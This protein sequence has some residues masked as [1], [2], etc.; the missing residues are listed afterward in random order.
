MLFT[1]NNICSVSISKQETRDEIIFFKMYLWV[2]D[3]N[4]WKLFPGLNFIYFQ[5]CMN[6]SH[7]TSTILRTW[8]A[9]PY[10]RSFY[11]WVKLLSLFPYDEIY[12]DRRSTTGFYETPQPWYSLTNFHV[13]FITSVHFLLHTLYQL[14]FT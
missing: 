8:Y 6:I 2:R 11:F 10:C 4:T 3:T 1:Y 12:V 5:Y 7:L 13:Y 14:F 9:T